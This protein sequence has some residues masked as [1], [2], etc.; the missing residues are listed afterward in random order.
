MT[1]EEID[2]ALK[3]LTA[4]MREKGLDFGGHGPKAWLRISD[5][6]APELVIWA[7]GFGSFGIHRFDGGNIPALFDAARAYIANH[8]PA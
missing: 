7:D 3:G 2:A 4:D 6:F 5:E 1:L 8:A